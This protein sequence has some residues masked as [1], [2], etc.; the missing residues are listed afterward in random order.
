M[1]VGTDDAE[2]GTARIPERQLFP[3]MELNSAYK[4]Q[5]E[6]EIF[7]ST[8]M[9]LDRMIEVPTWRKPVPVKT[10]NIPDARELAAPSPH[11]EL[12]S[13]PPSQPALGQSS[14]Q[15]PSTESKE[16]VAA[17]QISRPSFPSTSRTTFQSAQQIPAFE[18]RGQKWGPFEIGKD[19]FALQP[20]PL[21]LPALRHLYQGTYFRTWQPWNFE[22]FVNENGFA[23]R[24]TRYQPEPPLLQAINSKIWSGLARNGVRAQLVSQQFTAMQGDFLWPPVKVTEA[25]TNPLDIPDRVRALHIRNAIGDQIRARPPQRPALFHLQVVVG[26]QARHILMVPAPVQKLVEEWK[27]TADSQLWLFFEG[28][29]PSHERSNR[30][31]FLGAQF[32][33]N[34]AH[35]LLLKDRVLEVALASLA[36]FN[37]PGLAVLT[38]KA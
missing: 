28:M 35:Q 24:G 8:P 7:P 32:L 31:A 13:F 14:A 10:S 15:L 22:D 25:W 18:L 5:L 4:A 20:Y 34:G 12:S 17:E 21:D 37:Q 1:V 16:A 6:P 23:T 38:S 2:P 19:F 26:Y 3:V 33:P 29:R 9:R 36:A 11:T 27:S 30:L